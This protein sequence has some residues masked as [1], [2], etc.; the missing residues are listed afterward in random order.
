MND[1]RDFVEQ[2]EREAKV[3]QLVVLVVVFLI[4]VWIM[5]GEW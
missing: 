3:I 5:P 4:V 1:W 2:T